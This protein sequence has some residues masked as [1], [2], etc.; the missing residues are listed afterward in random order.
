MSYFDDG[1]D[2]RAE[3]VGALELVEIDSADGQTWRFMV[4]QSGVF[5]D[6]EGRAWWGA[7]LLQM[8]DIEM[9]INGTAPAGS[10]TLSYFQDPHPEAPD[11]VDEV[12]ALGLAYIEG[13]E[14]RVFT[15]PLAQVEDLFAPVSAPRR[16]VTRRIK[17]LT[18]SK[19][20]PFQRSISVQV[21]GPFEGRGTAPGLQYTRPDH[22]RLIGEADPSLAL[23]PTRVRPAEKLFT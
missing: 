9:S 14:M 5:T 10:L 3:V 1:F 23:M 15:Q 16:F 20:G 4:G 12:R 6:T 8:D 18:T 17:S 7:Q 22:E 2:A 21:G 19:D 13:Q 11:L